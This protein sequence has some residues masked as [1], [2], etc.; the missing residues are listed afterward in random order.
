MNKTVTFMSFGT[1]LGTA[2][3]VVISYTHLHSISWALIHGF[4]GWF[5][6]CY[7]AIWKPY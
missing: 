6:I 5:Y 7:Y 2:V 1:G 3:A 4:I